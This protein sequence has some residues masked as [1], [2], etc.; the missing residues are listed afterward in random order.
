MFTVDNP[1]AKLAKD[2]LAVA[3]EFENFKIVEFDTRFIV[4]LP[5]KKTVEFTI[6]FEPI[7]IFTE[8][9]VVIPV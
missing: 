1:I 8:F 5:E 9:T 7:E 4:E 3:V 6:V 2:K